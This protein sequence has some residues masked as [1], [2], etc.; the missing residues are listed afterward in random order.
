MAV[1]RPGAIVNVSGSCASEPGA[2]E[3]CSGVPKPTCL[4]QQLPASGGGEKGEGV[5]AARCW[6]DPSATHWGSA[7]TTH[8][9]AP[10][11]ELHAFPHKGILIHSLHPSFNADYVC[12]AESGWRSVQAFSIN[13]IQ[14]G[15]LLCLLKIHMV[16]NGRV[17]ICRAR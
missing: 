15:V 4:D 7:W 6:T 8:H 1:E 3:T 16:C 14:S 17:S 12:T 13:I 11:H 5:P 9:S 10:R 2:C